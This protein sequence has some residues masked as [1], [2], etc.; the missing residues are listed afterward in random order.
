MM[1]D[2]VVAYVFHISW[3]KKKPMVGQMDEGVVIA[4]STFNFS[5]FFLFFPHPH[6]TLWLV[7]SMGR[8][9]MTYINMQ[10]LKRDA[11]V[12]PVCIQWRYPLSRTNCRSSVPTAGY[13]CRTTYRNVPYRLRKNGTSHPI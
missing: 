5:S 3:F 7:K 2:G 9:V 6:C 11:A 8:Y 10:R 1:A 13:T 12:G 4:P